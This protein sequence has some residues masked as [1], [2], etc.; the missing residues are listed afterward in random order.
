MSLGNCVWEHDMEAESWLTHVKC[1]LILVIRIKMS[2]DQTGAESEKI[3]RTVR[4][5]H[6]SYLTNIR[7]TADNS[8]QRSESKNKFRL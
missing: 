8:D 3:L 2:Q 6:E 7:H 1:N 4:M 5:K